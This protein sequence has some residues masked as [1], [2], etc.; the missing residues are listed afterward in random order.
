MSEIAK[1][2]IDGEWTGSGTVSES[3]NPATGEVLGQWAD[4]GEAEAR[5][6][7]AAARH[8]FDTSP[9]SRDR[10]LRNRALIEMA[11]RFDAHADDLGA[12]VTKENGK[13]AGSAA[14]SRPARSG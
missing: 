8:A 1:H 2:W 12:L 7:I 6:A 10:G 13:T 3:V 11:A 14:R 5:A 4:G 9:W